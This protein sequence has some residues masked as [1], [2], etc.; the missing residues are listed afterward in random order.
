[1]SSAITKF[2]KCPRCGKP[3]TW[4]R[5][6]VF[7]PFCSERCKLIDLGGWAAGDYAIPAEPV[8]RET[9]YDAENP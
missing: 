1:M 3:V 5:D 2:V 9:D 7:K 6:Q 8:P 4:T